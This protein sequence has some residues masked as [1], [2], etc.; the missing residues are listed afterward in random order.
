MQLVKS[1]KFM[2]NSNELDQV[3]L[4][5]GCFKHLTLDITKHFV[6]CVHF[7]GKFINTRPSNKFN[8]ISNFMFSLHNT[9]KYK[10]SKPN[11]ADSIIVFQQC[12]K[13]V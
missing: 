2:E 13:M 4:E 12:K 5:H 11:S 8:F 9:V 6:W 10:R 7:T 3:K 1:A